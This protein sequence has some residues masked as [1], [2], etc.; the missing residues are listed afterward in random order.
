MSRRVDFLDRLSPD[1]RAALE[2]LLRRKTLKR[3]DFMFCQGERPERFFLLRAGC[4]KVSRSTGT[5]RDVILEILFPG[6]FCGALCALDDRPYPVSGV[7]L[8]E[9]TFDW[10]PRAEFLAAAE[11]RPG[12]LARAVPDCQDKMRQQRQMTVGMAVERAEQRAARVL[13]LLAERLGR[14]AEDGL[15]SPMVLDRQ[16]FS[17]LIGTTV[18]TAIRVLSRMRK[19]RLIREQ[20][21]T[22]LILDEA[23]LVTLAQGEGDEEPWPSLPVER[24]WSGGDACL[25]CLAS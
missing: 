10:I 5:G 18:E 15:Q 25:G 12:L 11:T 9:I 7:A 2:P 17:E 22:F 1:E 24:A 21:S 14:R 13:L 19:E 4:V 23:R 6:D 16:E 20:G 3:G 8:E